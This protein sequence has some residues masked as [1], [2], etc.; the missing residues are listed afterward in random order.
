[1]SKRGGCKRALGTRRPIAIPQGP[2]QRR[3]LDAVSDVLNDGRRFLILVVIDDFT[4]D[5]LACAVDNSL[6]GMRT[7][8]E[9]DRIAERRGYP[10]MIVSDNGAELASNAILQWQE[11]RNFEWH[12]IQPGKPIQ[13]GFVESFNSRLPDECLS[14]HLFRS[15]AHVRETIEK[16]RR[17]NNR[18]RPHTS[19]DGLTPQEFATRS[20]KDDNQNRLSP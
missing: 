14:E 17:D 5:C 18:L 4:H 6:S 2:N 20:I 9:L 19:L 13:N 15:L 11:E 12:Y 3:S 16:W 7:A 10:C 1:M 8:C